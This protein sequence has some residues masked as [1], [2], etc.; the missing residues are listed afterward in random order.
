MS[1]RLIQTS[2]IKNIDG[3]DFIGKKNIFGKIPKS[4]TVYSLRGGLMI[5]CH[6]SS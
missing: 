1:V 4:S 3:P 5:A 6:Y 2:S